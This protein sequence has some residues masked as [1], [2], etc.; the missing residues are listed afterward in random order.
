MQYQCNATT[1]CY[2]HPMLIT[3]RKGYLH[4]EQTHSFTSEFAVPHT[5]SN[6][7]S[8]SIPKRGNVHLGKRVLFVNA[9]YC[10]QLMASGAVNLLLQPDPLLFRHVTH[11]SRLQQFSGTRSA[12]SGRSS[13]P[14]AQYR[15]HHKP[16]PGYATRLRQLTV[17]F[18]VTDRTRQSRKII[19]FW[20]WYLK[21]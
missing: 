6:F 3:F 16:L 20:A 19:Q 11:N 17:N 10:P 1:A 7:K 13:Q 8:T 9:L 18:T 14:L 5:R 2:M 12:P 15:T 4:P 21:P